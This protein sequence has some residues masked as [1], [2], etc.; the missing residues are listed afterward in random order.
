MAAAAGPALQA[1][2]G[3]LPLGGLTPAQA[4]LIAGALQ[5]SGGTMTGDLIMTDGKTVRPQTEKGSDLGTALIGWA[6][7]H[8]EKTQ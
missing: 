1:G 3:S 7:A 2:G 5:K 6:T 4:A 8:V